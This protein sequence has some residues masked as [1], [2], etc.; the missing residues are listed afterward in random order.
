[1]EAKQTAV[2]AAAHL[3]QQVAAAPEEVVL[4]QILAVLVVLAVIPA[5]VATVLAHQMG[6]AAVAAEAA[7]VAAATVM[8]WLAA[9]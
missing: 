1:V 4:D 9:V 3:G 6:A 5:T 8:V 2:L 7:A